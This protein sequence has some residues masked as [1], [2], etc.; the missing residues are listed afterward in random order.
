VVVI[1]ERQKNPRELV[2]FEYLLLATN[3]TSTM[4]KELT[5]A[6]EQGFEFVGL[7]VAKTAM[8]GDEVVSILRRK[9]R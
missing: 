3:K 6:G 7:T 9:A 2:R 8:G 1:L 4:Q 5:Q